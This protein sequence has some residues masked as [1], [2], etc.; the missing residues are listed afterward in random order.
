MT[1]RTNLAMTRSHLKKTN[2]KQT[3]G[4]RRAFIFFKSKQAEIDWQ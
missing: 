2:A 1:N 3:E 4:K